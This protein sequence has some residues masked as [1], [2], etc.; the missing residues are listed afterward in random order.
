M[1]RIVPGQAAAVRNLLA[2]ADFLPA[3][4][5]FGALLILLTPNRQRLGDLA[6]GTII[7]RERVVRTGPGEVEHLIEHA[8][9]E[10]AFTAEQLAAVTAADIAIVRS[11]HESRGGHCS[12]SPSFSI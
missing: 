11:A 12:L 3:F 9:E 5:M 2:V 6:A 4:H 7:V 10:F 8:S 1:R